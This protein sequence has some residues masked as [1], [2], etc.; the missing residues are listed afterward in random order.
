MWGIVCGA[1]A[2]E[3]IWLYKSYGNSEH[4]DN[5]YFFFFFQNKS[6]CFF[7]KD[8]SSGVGEIG[9]GVRYLLCSWVIWILSL[10]HTSGVINISLLTLS[11]IT[12]E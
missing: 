10:G 9:Q 6:R 2:A 7:V 11:G 4:F 3:N 1:M 5:H 8:K 12:H